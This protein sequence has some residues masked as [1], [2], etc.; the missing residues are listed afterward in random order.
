M[1]SCSICSYEDIEPFFTNINCPVCGKHLTICNACYHRDVTHKYPIYQ[2]LSRKT[3][4]YLENHTQVN[5]V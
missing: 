1:C 2:R 3:Q 4:H 5:I